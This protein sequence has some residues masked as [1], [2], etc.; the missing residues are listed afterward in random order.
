MKKFLAA[1]SIL[2]LMLSG[3]G[4]HES[5]PIVDIVMP[6]D[7]DYYQAENWEVDALINEFKSLGFT[8]VV[9]ERMGT[10]S[11]Y[12]YGPIHTVRID[13]EL[14]GWDAGDT[15]KSNDEVEIRYYDP[16][17][18]LTIE[19]C[20]ELADVLSGETSSWIE[21]ATKYDGEYIEFDGCV[22]D[23]IDDVR[24]SDPLIYVC[25]GDFSSSSNKQ[26]IR[27]TYISIDYDVSRHVFY[28]E[29]G[30]NYKF[31]G[32]VDLDNSKFYKMLTIETVLVEDR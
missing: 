1:C 2:V 20:S 29:V 26:Q 6:K 27:L 11:D 5:T 3:C 21:F 10:D 23:R 32:K 31:V 19:N 24:L 16:T 15:Y 30:G 8:N 28:G 18:T 13:R 25:G 12:R 9:T 4:N 7:N 22:V 17:P 14:L